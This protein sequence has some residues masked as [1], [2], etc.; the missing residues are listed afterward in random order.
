MKIY[1]LKVNKPEEEVLLGISL[2]QDIENL[3]A[4][5]PI[6]AMSLTSSCASHRN[7]SNLRKQSKRLRV[8]CSTRKRQK[9]KNLVFVIPITCYI[10]ISSAICN[11]VL[12]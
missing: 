12:R 2:V 5:N 8:T 3:N 7:I 10:S 4:S 11:F 9:K 6:S 1:N